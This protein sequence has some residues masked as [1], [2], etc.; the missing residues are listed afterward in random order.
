MVVRYYIFE[1]KKLHQGEKVFP[2][3]SRIDDNPENGYVSEIDAYK[4]MRTLLDE[5]T[6]YEKSEL[7]IM[8]TY[9]K[10]VDEKPMDFSTMGENSVKT[11]YKIPIGKSVFQKI[12][13]F[14]SVN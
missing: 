5:N 4:N 7:M 3:T 14:I 8:K 2:F 9:S 12:K 13:D 11:S 6:T 10:Y 1:L